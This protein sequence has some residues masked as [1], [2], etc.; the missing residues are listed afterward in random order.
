MKN[1]FPS[2][3]QQQHEIKCEM[4]AVATKRHWTWKQQQET[5]LWGR[6]KL[7]IIFSINSTCLSHT[8]WKK[9]SEIRTK[10]RAK[11]SRKLNGNL[12]YKSNF[13]NF[14]PS[15][16]RSLFQTFRI[17]LNVKIIFICFMSVGGKFFHT[18]LKLVSSSRWSFLEIFTLNT[19]KNM[20]KL[21]LGGARRRENRKLIFCLW[22]FLQFQI[23]AKSRHSNLR[24]NIITMPWMS[25]IHL[26]HSSN[27]H[28]ENFQHFHFRLFT[29]KWHPYRIHVKKSEQTRK[30]FSTSSL[31]QLFNLRRKKE[32]FNF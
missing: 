5:S 27:F 28:I 9:K 20:E 26:S 10:T 23:F 4:A 17:K 19:I 18:I 21:Q 1:F 11:G 32:F 31:A 25:T 22:Q 30:H 16:F 13:P 2:T 3:R 6:W 29:N 24:V 15:L 14:C 8:N 12:L 7:S